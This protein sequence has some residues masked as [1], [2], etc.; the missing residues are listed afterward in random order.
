MFFGTLPMYSFDV[1]SLDCWITRFSETSTLSGV[2]GSDV[3]NEISELRYKMS[4][5]RWWDCGI[6]GFMDCLGVKGDGLKDSRMFIVY[7]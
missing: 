1:R 2:E 7:C 5:V 4:E 3:R 6:L